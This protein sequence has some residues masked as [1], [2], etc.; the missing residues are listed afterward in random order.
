[1]GL[2]IVRICTDLVGLKIVWDW[3]GLSMAC[4]MVTKNHMNWGWAKNRMDWGGAEN[5]T[6]LVKQQI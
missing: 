3:G 2:K 1:M 4:I 5:R 6:D